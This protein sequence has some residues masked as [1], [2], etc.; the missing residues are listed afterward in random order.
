MLLLFFLFYLH[1]KLSRASALPPFGTLTRN[2][3]GNV[4]REM[5]FVGVHKVCVNYSS[6]CTTHMLSAEL[7]TKK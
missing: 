6:N 3:I 4:S 5:Y 7:L 1:M 2:Q